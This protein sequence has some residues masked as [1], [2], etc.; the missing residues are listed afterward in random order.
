MSIKILVVLFSLLM[1]VTG[2]AM[3][4]SGHHGGDHASHKD[5]D[6]SDQKATLKKV[7]QEKLVVKVKGMVCAFC[8]QGIE[9]NFNKQKEVK[10]TKVDLDKMQVIVKLKSG[11][12]IPEKTVK[13][14]VTDAGFAY[15]GIKQ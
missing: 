4:H 7:G 2:F 9:T 6:H 3:D 8:A 11:K 15:D 14:I 13:K 1:S 12:T 5:H 10:E